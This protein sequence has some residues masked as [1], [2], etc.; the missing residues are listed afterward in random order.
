MKAVYNDL[1]DNHTTADQFG[2]IT[3]PSPAIDQIQR[4]NLGQRAHCK[5]LD[6]G[7]ET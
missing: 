3:Q 4:S 1:T 7:V 5:V 6:L 2:S